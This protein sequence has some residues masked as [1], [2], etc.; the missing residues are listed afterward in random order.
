MDRGENPKIFTNLGIFVIEIQK[1]VILEFF[2]I[3]EEFV[4]EIWVS[5]EAP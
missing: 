3:L 4:F 2:W 1:I 5:K